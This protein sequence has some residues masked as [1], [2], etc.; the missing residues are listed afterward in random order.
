MKTYRINA[1]LAV[2][3]GFSVPQLTGKSSSVYIAQ[4]T[5]SNEMENVTAVN[6]DYFLKLI[7]N[8]KCS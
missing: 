6:S 4:G 2:Y 1:I 7:D 3:L 5:S 8:F